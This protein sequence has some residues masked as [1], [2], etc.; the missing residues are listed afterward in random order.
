MTFVGA[1]D[2]G[3]AKMRF[4][5]IDRK[6]YEQSKQKKDKGLEALSVKLVKES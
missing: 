3:D 2:R 4:M 5:P 1:F 6:G